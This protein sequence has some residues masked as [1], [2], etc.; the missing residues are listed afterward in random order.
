MNSMRPLAEE[1]APAVAFGRRL[2]TTGRSNWLPSDGSQRRAPEVARSAPSSHSST[3]RAPIN[4]SA[5]PGGY[6]TERVYGVMQM[7]ETMTAGMRSLYGEPINDLATTF[8]AI[9]ADGDGF[10]QSDEFK[11]ALV[12]LDMGLSSDQM[13]ELKDYMDTDHNDMISY[14]EFCAAFRWMVGLGEGEVLPD[15][16]EGMGTTLGR[17]LSSASPTGD[18]RAQLAQLRAAHARANG[19][20]GGYGGDAAAEPTQWSSLVSPGRG[21]AGPQTRYEPEQAQRSGFT[22]R[23]VARDATR[24]RER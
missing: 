15:R 11:R 2:T 3:L 4:W 1:R 7:L 5:P 23:D 17:R 14:P 24:A 22:A 8:A 13:D 19:E 12:R 20:E 10:L 16:V 9:D 6:G 18:Q 21:A